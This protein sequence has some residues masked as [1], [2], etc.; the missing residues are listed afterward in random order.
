MPFRAMKK[1][2]NPRK[3]IISPIDVRE[4]TTTSNR[5]VKSLIRSGTINV[6]DN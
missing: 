1:T 5:G 6:G 2:A 4:L 3:F